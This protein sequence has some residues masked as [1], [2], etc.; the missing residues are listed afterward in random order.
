[1]ISFQF[2]GSL[3]AFLPLNIFTENLWFCMH[4]KSIFFFFF[5]HHDFIALIKL[6]KMH[7]R[8]EVVK[9][10]F[11]HFV[12]VQQLKMQWQKCKRKVC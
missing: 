6:I 2:A 12:M 10:S 7:C 1:M 9:I 4:V 3:R 8:E 5:W 11:L